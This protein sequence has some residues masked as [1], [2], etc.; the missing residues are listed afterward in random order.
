MSCCS[1]R[2]GNALPRNA[3]YR[4]AGATPP[5]ARNTSGSLVARDPVA[6]RTT[7]LSAIFRPLCAARLRRVASCQPHA[8]WDDITRAKLAA[9]RDVGRHHAN[10][11]WS[12]ARC[13]ATSRES[14]LEP[15]AMWDDITR[16][17]PA[18]SRDVGRHHAYQ[19]HSLANQTHCLG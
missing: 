10:Q 3:A 12:L 11:S 13:R 7:T 4:V 14:N 1:R 6:G 17:K 5:P 18:A 15:R 19:T 16:A 8:L 9:S 2:W